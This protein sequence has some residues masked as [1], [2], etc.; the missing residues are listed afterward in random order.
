MA[1]RKRLVQ[2]R[3]FPKQHSQRPAIRN[4]VMHGQHQHMIIVRQPHEHRPEQ[5][6]LG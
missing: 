3:Q 6:A 1:T 5:R 4:D 2:H